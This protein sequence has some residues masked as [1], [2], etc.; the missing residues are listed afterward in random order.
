[1]ITIN[2]KTNLIDF[3]FNSAARKNVNR[4]SVDDLFKV[5]EYLEEEC[6]GPFSA[7][8]INEFFENEFDFICENILFR[9]PADVA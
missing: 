5:Q 9:D 3:N 8:D 4:L 2:Y 6:Y 7:K 1:M